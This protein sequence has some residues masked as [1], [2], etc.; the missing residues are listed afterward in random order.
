MTELPQHSVRNLPLVV[1]ISQSEILILGG[2]HLGQYTNIEKSD[3]F[4]Y[5]TGTGEIADEF[6]C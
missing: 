5:N 1:P 2:V 4:I 3:G 6:N